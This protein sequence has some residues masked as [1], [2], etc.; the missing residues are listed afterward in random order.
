MRAL[1]A[2]AI[3]GVALAFIV[4]LFLPGLSQGFDNPFR[5]LFRSSDQ[6]VKHVDLGNDHVGFGADHPG[7]NS[8]PATSGSHY[9]Q[10]LAPASWGV[11][12]GALEDEVLIHNLEH[13]GIGVHYDC[14]DGCDALVQQ[15][16]EI[17]NGST[18]KGLKVIMS[19]YPNMGSRIALTAWTYL[20]ELDVIDEDRIKD[21][22]NGHES[23][24]TAPEPRAR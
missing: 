18:D 23:S 13:G 17:V 5:N 15:L 8:V 1:I 4:G 22:I 2:T 24:S 11:H 14:P 16:A 19:P 6:G 21:F 9:V 12:E 7:Y 10:P 20:D 3:A